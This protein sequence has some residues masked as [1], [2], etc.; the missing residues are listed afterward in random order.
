MLLRFVA[1]EGKSIASKLIKFHTRSSKYS[2]I[3]ILVDGR[4][5]EAWPHGKS[6]KSWID[7]SDFNSHKPGT[8][9]EIWGLSVPTKEYSYC[10]DAWTQMAED[11]VKYDWWGILGFLLKRTKDVE[12]KMFCS[13]M[14]I[15]PL[16]EI[17]K[18]TSVKPFHISP[19]MF[20]CLIQA[21]GAT[22]LTTDQV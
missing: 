1:F 20:V 22:L 11:K 19:E 3:A 2:H 7:Y 5:I 16:V 4:L 6:M 12:S 21:M 8:Q 18:L 17:K 15:K 10:V 9:Y 14:A 13:E